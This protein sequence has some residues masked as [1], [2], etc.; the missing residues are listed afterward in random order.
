MNDKKKPYRPTLIVEISPEQRLVLDKFGHGDIKKTFSAL[1]DQIGEI[2]DEGISPA[3]LADILCRGEL[4][5]RDLVRVFEGEDNAK[6][7]ND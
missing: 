6:P 7:K 2:I 3:I 5:I 4:N 1:I